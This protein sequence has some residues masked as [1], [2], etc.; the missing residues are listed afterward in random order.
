M[1]EKIDNNKCTGCGICAAV[2]PLDTIRVDPFQKKVP[3]CQFSCPAM[4]DIRGYIHFLKNRMPW[5]A[6]HI[7]GKYLPYPAI[8]GR[9]CHHPCELKCA[10]T[11]VD[12]AVDINGLERYVGDN[13]LVKGP[14]LEP[15]I[16]AGKVAVVGSGAAGLAAAYFLVRLGYGVTV[17]EGRDEIGGMLKDEVR[18]NRLPKDILEAQVKYM[19]DMG[20]EFKTKVIKKN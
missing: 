5:E 10:R 14:D 7:L 8:T 12:E 19:G 4:V 17:F 3:P 15:R 6:S 13:M 20:V 2:C 1:I 9:L 11:A 18:K 16:H